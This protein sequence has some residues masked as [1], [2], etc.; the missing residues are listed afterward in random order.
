MKY[1]FRKELTLSAM[2]YLPVVCI[3]IMCIILAGCN[4]KPKNGHDTAT[5]DNGGTAG[6]GYSDSSASSVRVFDQNGRVCV[7]QSNTSYEMVNIVESDSKTPLLLK[8]KKTELCFADSV[9]KDKVY[10]ISGKSVLDSKSVSWNI[11]FVATD[12][13]FKD[14]TIIATKEGTDNENDFIKRFSLL[15]GNEVFSCSFGDLEV[16]VPNVIS[17]FF[18]GYTS[19]KA[20]S[21]PLALLKDENLLG[22]VRIGSSDAAIDSFKIK[23]KR[24]KM[25]DKLFASVPDL[26]LASTGDNTTAIDDGRSL[27][28][29]GDS[30]YQVKDVQ[31]FGVKFTYYYGDDNETINIFVPVDKGKFDIAHATYD[32]DIFEISA[33]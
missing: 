28:L 5:S 9:N 27:I 10:E 25:A 6:K 18:I 8:I 26:I 23:L 16:K 2:R 15:N 1:K 22:V 21:G 12:I 31:G 4:G 19:K 11:S 20:A 32:K 17:K 30:R 24:S 14:N 3:F 13:S 33:F 7:Q 29:K